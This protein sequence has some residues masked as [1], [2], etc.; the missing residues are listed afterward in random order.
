MVFLLEHGRFS[1]H[2]GCNMFNLGISF[3]EW[4]NI[5]FTVEKRHIMMSPWIV[6]VGLRL[7]HFEKLGL[8]VPLWMTT[9]YMRHLTI[10]V[11]DIKRLVTL[12]LNLGHLM[13]LG[14]HMWHIL[15]HRW[16]GK[17]LFVMVPL[18]LSHFVIMLDLMN[19]VCFSVMGFF[20]IF[21]LVRLVVILGISLAFSV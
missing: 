10:L 6:D 15:M 17:G 8:C 3:E 5:N 19:A 11:F 2:C 13:M 14:L 12:A 4:L 7:R 18:D 9:L 16:W 20:Y 1:M 21:G